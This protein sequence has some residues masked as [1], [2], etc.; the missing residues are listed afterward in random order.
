MNDPER[1][2][3]Y[4]KARAYREKTLRKPDA[5]VEAEAR[6]SEHKANAGTSAGLLAF[7]RAR[8]EAL[9]TLLGWYAEPLQRRLRFKRFLNEQRSVSQFCNRIRKMERRRADGSRV[10][11]VIAYGA[12]GMSNGLAVKGLPPCINTG[13]AKKLSRHFLVVFVPEH[14]TSQRCFHCKGKC[15]NHAYLAERG[16]SY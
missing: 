9:P 11:L 16:Q 13:L 8:A 7:L 4:E 2:E 15:G 10:P 12:K 1:R 14:Y 5:V 6:L 3:K